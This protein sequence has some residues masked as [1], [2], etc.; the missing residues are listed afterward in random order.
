M[1]VRESTPSRHLFQVDVCVSVCVCARVMGC[2]VH[3]SDLVLIR[4]RHCSY[5]TNYMGNAGYFFLQRG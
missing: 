5:S 3:V 4:F 2:I 1:V